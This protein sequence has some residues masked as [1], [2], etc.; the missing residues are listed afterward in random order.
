[1]ILYDIQTVCREHAELERQAIRE[2]KEHQVELHSPN[3]TIR[4]SEHPLWTAGALAQRERIEHI[5]TRALH[6]Y[7]GDLVEIGAWLGQTT[8]CLARAAQVYARKVIV[9]DPYE[10][11]TQNCGG[12]EYDFFADMVA[13][14]GDT[15]QHVRLRSQDQRVKDFLRA[16]EIAF[17]FVDGLHTYTAALDDLNTVSHAKVIALDDMFMAPVALAFDDF[18]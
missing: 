2:G 6:E 9:I 14:F 10:D 11:G 4:Y 15:V 3:L 18:Q 1:M 16:Q 5:A 13:P 7:A 12:Q 8:V 17:A